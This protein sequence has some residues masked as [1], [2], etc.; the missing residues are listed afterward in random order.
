[1]PMT[2][3]NA[4]RRRGAGALAPLLV[5][6]LL[7]GLALVLWLTLGRFGGGGTSAPAA[8]SAG[9]GGDSALLDEAS[10]AI[11]EPEAARSSAVGAGA[12]ALAS[13][14]LGGQGR[15]EGRVLERA[16]GEPVAGARVDLLALPPA[17]VGVIG[18]LLRLSGMGEEM[19][20]RV[21]P[22]ATTTS[23]PGGHF[24][25]VGVRA[26]QYFAEARGTHSVPDGAV[27]ARVAPSGSGGPIDLW[28]RRGGRVVGRVVHPDGSPAAGARV[29]LVPGPMVFL[30]R[31]LE[32]DFYEAEGETDEEGAFAL[33]GIP[34]GD[35]Y[36]LAAVGQGFTLSYALDLSVRPG[37]DTVVKV[38]TRQ[39]TVLE[40][41]VVSISG[42][43]DPHPELGDVPLRGALV[44]AVPL[45]L[46]HLRFVEE[47]LELCGGV[48]DAEGGFTL[49]QV[50]P[51]E[52]ELVG[53]AP[54]HV[55]SRGPRASCHSGAVVAMGDFELARGPVVHGRVV[56]EAGQPVAGVAVRWNPVDWSQLGGM[57]TFAP[58]L[59]QALEGFDFPKTGGDGRFEAGAFPGDPDY[60][61]TAYKPGYQEKSF[62]WNPDEHGEEIEI[63][64]ARGGS[65]AGVVKNAADGEPLT[66]FTIATTDRIEAQGQAP[67]RWNPFSGGQLVE[68]PEGRFHIDSLRAG[69]VDLTFSAPG[70]AES[71]LEDVQIT[72]GET[73]EG[74]VV[75]LELGGL[76]RGRVVNE[77]GRAVAG[78]QVFPLSAERGSGPGR[79]GPRGGGGE[80]QDRRRRRQA[81]MMGAMSSLPPGIASYAAAVGLMG[82]GAELSGQDGRFELSGVGFGRQRITALHRDYALGQSEV[83]ELEPGGSVPE[84]EIVLSAGSGIYGKASDRLGQPV[85]DGIVVAV[86]PQMGSGGGG[87][88]YQGHTEETGDY[89]IE[90]MAPGGYFMVLTRGDEALN[91][92][93][94]LG[95][96]NFDLVRVPEGEMVEFDIVDTSLGGCRVHGR[97]TVGGAPVDRG[98]VSAVSFE[99]GGLLGVDFKVTS[100]EQDGTYE[101]PG[102]S[103]GE[104][105]FNIDNVRIEG[106]N[107][108]ARLDV[109][110]PNTPE[111]A[112][113][114]EF[115]ES[116]LEVLVVDAVAGEPVGRAEVLLQRADVSDSGGLLGSLF[117][118]EGQRVR[119]RTDERGE[120][121]FRFLEE[122]DYEVVVRPPPGERR[123]HGPAGPIPVRL[124][125]NQVERNF[126]VR[127]EPALLLAGVVSS[128]GGPVSGATLLAMRTDV[129]GVPP[130]RGSSGEDGRYEILGLREGTYQIRASR[131]GYAE[132][133]R[134]DVEIARGEENRL[135]V[136]LEEGIEVAVLVTDPGGKPLSGA[137]VRLR[138]PDGEEDAGDLGGALM[139]FFSGAGTTDADGRME[140]G[141]FASGTWRLEAQRGQQRAEPRAVELG[142]DPRVELRVELE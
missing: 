2:H 15:L 122:G 140:L 95:S 68:D 88:I 119:Q 36:D 61:I 6:A 112:Y 100:I 126:E 67:G 77:E 69:S 110:V 111:Y 78:A 84:V 46:R 23:D 85:T 90:H 18:R 117:S 66:S 25:L 136:E 134:R 24:A 131:A 104:Y 43:H 20:E 102:L 74:L 65:A 28:V 16:G 45:G 135:D 55:G 22:V 75:E 86:S 129:V 38:T 42:D 10:V 108:R 30:S 51:G 39:G 80:A 128:K 105:Q 116:G 60:E 107:L 99:A 114:L 137:V 138:R 76:V 62:D 71:D 3:P 47:I 26:G 7:T 41:R 56:D 73:T 93:S 97:V 48:T 124:G 70:F 121:V 101:F 139:S 113:D 14:R 91:P 52:V 37:E 123:R 125:W 9:E 132:A 32:G 21:R 11:E 35:G 92:M 79:R 64:L 17:G 31:L 87:G 5:L 40:G 34:A 133:V 54:G 106:E 50:P 141:R 98:T 83:L 4:S 72:A 53:W 1:M 115:P 49:H 44:A 81:G 96:L 57:V 59:I 27:L 63:V 94:F 29:A 58:L 19:A 12:A 89:R 120:A 127:L 33:S 109:D 142:D 103:P 130:E 118:R 82:D 8:T 13:V